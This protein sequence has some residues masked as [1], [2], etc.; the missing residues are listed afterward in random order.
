MFYGFIR[1]MWMMG[2][3]TGDEVNAYVP[4]F[5]TADEAEMILVT[6]TKEQQ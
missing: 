4:K 6:P 2:K 3:L 5:L 1:N